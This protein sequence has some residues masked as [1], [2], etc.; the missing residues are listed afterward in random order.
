MLHSWSGKASTS[1]GLRSPM[2]SKFSRSISASPQSVSSTSQSRSPR[3]TLTVSSMADASRSLNW[4]ISI[5][6]S[7]AASWSRPTW[8]W[9]VTSQPMRAS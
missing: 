9:N 2:W 7:A 3:A 6:S 4:S 8:S 5:G 1:V